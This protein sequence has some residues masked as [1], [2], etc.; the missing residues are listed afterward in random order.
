MP[1]LFLK[2]LPVQVM[3][4]FST[5]LL[6]FGL[7][8]GC[9]AA[10]PPPMTADNPANPSAPE[11]TVRPLHNTLGTDSLTKKSRQILAQSAKEQQQWDQGGPASGEQKEQEM[12]NLPGSPPIQDQKSPSPTT[13]HQPMPGM[14]MPPE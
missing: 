2:P 5:S 12:K 11:A 13:P 1:R 7:L 6:A 8:A 9:A 4:R 14:A 10:P 3:E